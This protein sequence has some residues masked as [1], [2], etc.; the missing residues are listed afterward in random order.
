LAWISFATYCLA[1][2]T[3][4]VLAMQSTL[5][6]AQTWF[7]EMGTVDL[8]YGACPVRFYN[9]YFSVCLF[10]RNNV[11]LSQQI[12]RNSVSA[13]F[14]SEA[15]GA[16]GLLWS[17]EYGRPLKKDEH[18]PCC[19]FQTKH[20]KLYKALLTLSDAWLAVALSIISPLNGSPYTHSFDHSRLALLSSIILLVCPL[21]TARE[22]KN[23]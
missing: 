2:R 6:G 3:C 10:R 19:Y 12:S 21:R 5:S 14:F 23:R 15:N 13:C 20:V 17:R 9:L 1:T 22:I 4:V 18:I 8:V 11:F 16:H 7:W